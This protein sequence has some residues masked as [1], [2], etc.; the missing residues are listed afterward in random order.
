VELQLL[1]RPVR[2]QFG[3]SNLG[4]PVKRSTQQYANVL[5]T[6]SDQVVAAAM[7][8]AIIAIEGG[9]PRELV[10][11]QGHGDSDAGFPAEWVVARQRSPVGVAAYAAAC[12]HDLDT[13]VKLF[14]TSKRQTVRLAVATN[15]L[16]P[17]EVRRELAAFETARAKPADS[18]LLALSRSQRVD[19]PEE[20]V[21]R[22][23]KSVGRRSKKDDQY[24]ALFD[25]ARSKD[26]TNEQID[27]ILRAA[28]ANGY[29]SILAE[30]V[31]ER[32]APGVD[33]GPY[34]GRSDLPLVE[35]LDAIDAAGVLEDAIGEASAVLNYSD[36]E[37]VVSPVMDE[38]M[39][40]PRWAWLA[41]AY[42]ELTDEQFVALLATDPWQ[43][44]DGQG[45]L[46]E[47][48]T[49]TTRLLA[50]LEAAPE[51]WCGARPGW[52]AMLDKSDFC[53]LRALFSHCDEPGEG[54]AWFLCGVSDSDDA[55]LASRAPDEQCARKLVKHFSLTEDLFDL[56]DISPR[57]GEDA[58]QLFV[59]LNC[60]PGLAAQLLASRWASDVLLSFVVGRLEASFGPSVLLGLELL[61]NYDLTL[62]DVCAGGVGVRLGK[63]G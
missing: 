6:T 49:N 15:P 3:Y 38:L 35:M 1:Y 17:T 54:L 16:V 45:A 11:A 24:D 2:P 7:C 44:E 14:K 18:V 34:S 46:V 12:C 9:I 41:C 58:N 36:L 10:V 30:V 51:N 53:A 61:G 39:N 21:A 43:H 28:I 52:A 25:A 26:V 32:I 62:E 47:S 60:V 22:A 50:L 33:I 40:R 27:D 8:D 48:T 23:M 42:L 31:A 55:V 13:L 37:G 19:S 59:L 63:P 4:A 29:A 5:E 56:R 57:R 20:L